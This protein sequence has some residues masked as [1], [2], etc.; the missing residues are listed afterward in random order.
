VVKNNIFFYRRFSS[1]GKD[2]ILTQ[3]TQSGPKLRPCRN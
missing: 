2:L 1:R 3:R